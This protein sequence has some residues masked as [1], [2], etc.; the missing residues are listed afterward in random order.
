MQV[1]IGALI[2]S[3]KNVQIV[4]AGCCDFLAQCILVRINHCTH[5]PFYSPKISKIYRCWIVWGRNIR[6]VI[7][8]SFL[9]IAFLGRSIYLHLISRFQF[10][11]S[12]YLGSANFESYLV[13]AVCY[14]FRCDHHREW[15]GNG[16]D[17]V[18]DP[19]G[20]LGSEGYYYFCRANFG[21]N[22]GYQITACHIRNN[23]IRYD[24]ASHPTGSY[25]AF[26]RGTKRSRRAGVF[27]SSVL[28]CHR[29]NV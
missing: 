15:P 18:Q 24:V 29:R 17:C 28:P 6:V 22:W 19:Q 3:L 13:S 16:L 12:S 23:R 27:C 11:A 5:R 25:G 20:V 9:A 2:F 7:I 26:R 4:L 8:P 14:K 1:R 10:I 21:L